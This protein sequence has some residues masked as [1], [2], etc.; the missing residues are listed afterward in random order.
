MPIGIKWFQKWN[1]N[2]A[3]WKKPHNF[4]K[5]PSK[6]QLKKQRES[7][8]W[9]KLTQE[10]KDKIS[11]KN[12]GKKKPPRTEEH[13]RKISENN[14]GSKNH[15]WQWWKSFE[16][17][18]IDWTNTLRQSIRERDKYV[19]KICWEK[20]WDT[21]HSVHHIDYDKKNC[22]PSNL[23]T[24]CKSCHTKTNTNREYWINYFKKYE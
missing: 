4:G 19:C 20:Q 1:N 17:Y 22:N 5:H 2:P 14:S 24:L 11:K 9:H 18:T 7:H 10:Q 12:K 21:A 15:W 8:L 3:F 16:R 23:I 13:K 6:E